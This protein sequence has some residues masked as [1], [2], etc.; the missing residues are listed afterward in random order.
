MIGNGFVFIRLCGSFP[1]EVVFLGFVPD[2]IYALDVSPRLVSVKV[3]KVT[4][5]HD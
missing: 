5:M 2:N 4:L 1:T 3:S